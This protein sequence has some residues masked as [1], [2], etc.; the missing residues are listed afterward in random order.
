[1][2]PPGWRALANHYFSAR[3]YSLAAGLAVGVVGVVASELAMKISKK[4]EYAIRA[5]VMIARGGRDSLH[6]IQQLSRD[7]VIPVKFLEQIL[8]ILRHAGVLSSRRGVKGGYALARDPEKVTVGE[9]IRLMDGPLAPV[10][11]ASSEPAEKCSCPDPDT[12]ALRMLMLKVRHEL[13]ETL[14]NCSIMDVVRM[15][16]GQGGSEFVI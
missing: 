14:D 3:I 7:E 12:C 6:Q 4:S 5:L 1:M 16:H 2:W 13:S 10:P 15:S 11:C 9:V 8:L